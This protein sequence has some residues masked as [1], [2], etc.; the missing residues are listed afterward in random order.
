MVFFPLTYTDVQYHLLKRMF[1]IFDVIEH[2]KV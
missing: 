1:V 2:V